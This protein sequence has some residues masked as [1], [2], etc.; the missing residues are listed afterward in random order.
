M[1]NEIWVG[2]K[3]MSTD[4][5]FIIPESYKE[6][7]LKDNKE[8]SGYKTIDGVVYGRTQAIWYTNIDHGRRHE[9]LSLMSMSDNIKY[10]KHIQIR[11]SEYKKFDNYAA[12][13][14]PFVDAIP[15][16]YK[17]I[18]AVPISFL[19][20]HCP[21]QFEIVGRTGDIE[22]ASNNCTFFTPPPQE[23]QTEYKRMNKTWRVQNAYMVDNGIPKTFYDRIFIRYTDE[24]IASHPV[25]FE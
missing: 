8:G 23:V 16:D 1:N 19:D 12:L 4:A 3:S 24:W 20:K 5:Y 13:E 25:D 14:I 2:C 15:S 10:S 6:R 7:L 21:E 18:M 22:W 9:P 17:D 11:N